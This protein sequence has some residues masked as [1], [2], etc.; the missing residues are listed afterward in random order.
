MPADVW[1]SSR[2]TTMLPT[3]NA[4]GPEVGSLPFPYSHALCSMPSGLHR[5]GAYL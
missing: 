3:F 5:A 4:G 2:C 1:D